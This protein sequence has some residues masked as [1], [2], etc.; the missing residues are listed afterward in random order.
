[1][2]APEVG[3]VRAAIGANRAGKRG[4]FRVNVPAIKSGI[5]FERSEKRCIVPQVGR[6][7]RQALEGM[8][9]LANQLFS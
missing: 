2:L 1:M 3:I 5:S 7:S 4:V 9:Q 6:R 8:R